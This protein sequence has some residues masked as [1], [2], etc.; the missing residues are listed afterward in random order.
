MDTDQTTAS[1]EERFEKAH[2]LHPAKPGEALT[3]IAELESELE[4][5]GDA[6][7]T[8]RYIMLKGNALTQSGKLDDA[9]AWLAQNE[10]RL[11]ALGHIRSI[12][13]SHNLKGVICSRRSDFVK[14][15]KHFQKALSLTD[16]DTDPDVLANIFG[17]LGINFSYLGEHSAAISALED[18]MEQWKK[19]EGHPGIIPTLI[20]LGF[21][22]E[23]AGMKD[24]APPYYE[25]AYQL[26]TEQED[27]IR[28]VIALSNWST[29]L[30]RNGNL[31]LAR[32]KGKLAVDIGRTLTSRQPFAH[33]LQA[34]AECCIRS[35]Q[36][37]EAEM[38][39]KEALSIYEAAGNR[40]GIATV[41]AALARLEGKAIPA[42]KA[43]WE[44]SLQTAREA[45]LKHEASKALAALA[46]LAY[47]EGDFAGACEM[48]Q[49]VR[50]LESEIFDDKAQKRFAV[51]GVQRD[52]DKLQLDL[53]AERIRNDKIATLLKE[54]Q[55]QRERIEEESRQKSAILEIAAHDLRNLVSGVIGCLDI[56]EQHLRE[57]PGEAFLKEII[58]DANEAS[59]DL[60]SLLVRLMDVAAIQRG[61]LSIEMDNV[62]VISLL[63]SVCKQLTN[64]A[65]KKN[66][67][68]RFD[69]HTQQRVRADAERLRQMAV[70]LLGNAL[71][72]SPSNSEVV[73]SVKSAEN[74]SLRIEFADRGPG[75]SPE[76]QGKMCRPFQR[77]SATPTGGESSTGLGLHIVKS[78]VEK[79]NG[80]FG[81]ADNPGGGSIFFIELPKA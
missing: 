61:E 10:Q 76:D 57:L 30:V 34:W 31:T 64:T 63:Q 78:M 42:Q 14:S 68:I 50:K 24:V 18:S 20:N 1:L 15:I 58:G 67:T 53:H 49:S 47:A 28:Q 21:S 69:S 44:R 2:S 79:Q 9:E 6:T 40:R 25:R 77:L 80:R 36:L 38:S 46:D 17:N 55:S 35:N 19:L 22:S 3:A 59:H 48:L 54:V 29:N 43:H 5:C 13:S 39:L 23:E 65:S 62:D 11:S 8:A 52:I 56:A 41:E 7:L 4:T 75:L 33:A 71:K 45:G 16:P 51:L 27:A 70:N 32:E 26:A 37:P 60:L 74:G 81:Y 12:I 72:Y 66:Q 73:L